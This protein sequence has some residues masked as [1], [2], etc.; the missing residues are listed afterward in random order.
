MT[1]QMN[2]TYRNLMRSLRESNDLVNRYRK[3]VNQ[4][5]RWFFALALIVSVCV[6]LCVIMGF[7]I[8]GELEPV[9]ARVVVYVVLGVFTVGSG[10]AATFL[11]LVV[12]DLGRIE[13]RGS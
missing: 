8:V 12:Q 6:L 11:Y 7:A 13:N 2:V 9:W 3:K 4:W 1:E 10:C 5:R